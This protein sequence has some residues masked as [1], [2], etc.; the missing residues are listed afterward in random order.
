MYLNDNFKLTDD[1]CSEYKIT[2]L[3]SGTY[4]TDKE[5]ILPGKEQISQTQ[6]LFHQVRNKSHKPGAYFTKTSSQHPPPP[7]AMDHGNEAFDE[8]ENE[9][10]SFKKVSDVHTALIGD[11]NA[12]TGILNDFVLADETLLDLFHLDT[13]NEI[14]SYMLDYENLKSYNIPLQRVTQCNC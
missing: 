11:F 6:N 12:N 14:I 3:T 4:F 10:M 8:I 1:K 9:L 2:C 7:V 13:D 5:L